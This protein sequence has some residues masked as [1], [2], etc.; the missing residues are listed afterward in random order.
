MNEFEKWV[1]KGQ[2]ISSLSLHNYQSIFNKESIPQPLVV[3]EGP[4]NATC[5]DVFSRLMAS[6][7]IFLGTPV[8]EEAANI[9]TAQLL[10][11]NTISHDPI[12]MYINTPGGSVQDGLQIYDTMQM[13]KTP[14]HT[15]VTGMAASMGS[16]LLAG[17]E[18]GYRGALPNASVMIHQVLGGCYG[19]SADVDIAAKEI[20]RLQNTLYDILAD[21]TGKSFKQIAK[22]ADRDHWMSADQA[23][24]YGIV[25]KVFNGKGIL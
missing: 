19:Q 6:R 4:L 23:C 5:V 21:C 15:I 1:I 25:D 24:E 17:G 22:D 7:V 12:Q 10:F 20:K 14:V 11:L 3:E 8:S 2:G 16:I 18:K 13:I 9:I